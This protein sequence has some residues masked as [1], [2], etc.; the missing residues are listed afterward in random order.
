MDKFI[1]KGQRNLK[2][3]VT[4]SGAKNVAMKVILAGLLTDEKLIIEGV[5]HISSVTGT[6]AIVKP[7]GV[8][9]N[10]FDHTLEVDAGSIKKSDVSLETGGLYRTA[11]MVLGPLLSRFGRARVPNPGG[12]RIGE[13]PI[14]RHIEAITKMGAKI[15]YNSKDGFFYATASKLKGTS[16]T[17]NKNSHTGTETLILASVL[18]EGETIIDNAAFEPEVDDLIKLLNQMGA[19]IKR[20]EERKLVIKGVKKLHGT[21]FRIM[22]DRNEVVTYAIAA[23]VTGGDIMI[24]GTQRE[25]LKAFLEKLDKAACGWEPIGENTTR[26]YAKGV[27]KGAD[28]TTLPYPGFMT[29]WQ[30]PWAV[31]MTQADG[32]STIHETIFENRFSYVQELKKMGADISFFTPSVENPEQLYNFNC[33]NTVNNKDQAIKIKGP[34]KLHEAILRTTDLRAGATLILAALSSDGESYV[35]GLEHI[36]RGYEKIDERLKSLGADIKRIKE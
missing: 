29:D 32:I 9:V 6:A 20:K 10:F 18:A 21:T 11:T 2:G 24:H 34:T 1:I 3:E 5:P 25:Y 17:F 28:I 13:R 16:F 26:F 30:A 19:N 23:L 7:L 12:C 15:E 27:I 8:N 14:D 35:H 36:D 31:L 4:V 33:D 22:P